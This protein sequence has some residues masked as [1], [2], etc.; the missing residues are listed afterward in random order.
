[1][2]RA[3]GGYLNDFFAEI[4]SLSPLSIPQLAI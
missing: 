3:I 2:Y 1:L 4:S